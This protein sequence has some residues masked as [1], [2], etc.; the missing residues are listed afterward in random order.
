MPSGSA[1]SALLRAVGFLLLSFAL[2]FERSIFRSVRSFQA[3]AC[4]RR[5]AAH[6]FKTVTHFM[7]AF[8]FGVVM[9]AKV[10]NIRTFLRKS[11]GTYL[12]QSK[13]FFLKI[14]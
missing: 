4:L 5:A 10:V 9:S 7:D 2:Q 6:L 12:K 3:C 1:A 14:W 11:F 13:I 8:I